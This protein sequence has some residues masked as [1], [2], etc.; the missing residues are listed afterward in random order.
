MSKTILVDAWQT[1]VLETG[2]FTE[3]KAIL[4][5]FDSRKIIVTN[6][7]KEE[8]AKLGIVN[9]PYEV[10]SLNHEPDKIDP[11][12]FKQLLVH[13]SLSPNEVIYFERSEES[14]K[15]A[16]SLGIKSFWYNEDEKDLK[17]LKQFLTENV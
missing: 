8:K 16:E 2:V 4:D 5:A 17:A 14:V 1:F 15:A 3:M 10:Y 9:M 11:D 6:A 12:Y 7:N 13:Y